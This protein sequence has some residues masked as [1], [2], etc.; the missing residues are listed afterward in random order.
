MTP[1]RF[2]HL[3]TLV[4]PL[5][6]K[7]TT[8]FREPISAFQRLALT[9]RF[10]ATGESQQS[11]SFSY[12]I[13]KATVSKFVSETSLA[14]YNSLKQPYL[15]PPSSKEEWLSISSGFEDCWNFPH[16]LGAIDGKHIR[17]ECPK[18]T[19]SYYYNYKGFYS[20][21]LLAT[22]DSNFCFTLFDLGHYGINNESGVLAKS[23]M[24]ETQKIGIPEPVK[25]STCD[26]DPL[27]YFLVGDEIFPL[28]TWLMRPYPGTLDKE[29]RIFNY[30]LSR[31][32]RTIENAFAILC[33]RRRIFYT[34]IRAKVEN[35]VLA[36]LALHNYLRLTDNASYCP[37]G[38]T[39][40][41]DDTGNLQ[42]G[43]LRT[44]AV[45]NEGILPLSL[46]KG[47][48]YSNNAVKMRN[49]LPRF[50][51]SEEGRVSWQEEHVT[52]IAYGKKRKVFFLF[53]I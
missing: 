13:E 47:S 19:G 32:R 7:R 46:V 28:K 3:L 43:K 25:H 52:R 8:R 40:S 2:E 5:L 51:N 18:L 11:L 4:A 27:P 15:K 10:L 22:C 30:R 42:E 37:S 35:F 6:E 31:A 48:R 53:C 24:V 36:C 34:P 23:E 14:R 50:L 17:I 9:L 29:Q 1:N 21:V 16:C 38:F 49:S 41:Y 44:L 12:R 26:F 33:A 39:D 20:T 45:G